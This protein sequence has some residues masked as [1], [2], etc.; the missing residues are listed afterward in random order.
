MNR[1][2]HPNDVVMW[3]TARLHQDGMVSASGTI[4]DKRMAL[5]LLDQA[6][7][8]IKRQV[9]EDN[10]VMI[11]NRDVSVMPSIPTK[12]MAHIPTSERGDG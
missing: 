1:V 5:H 8:A 6:R 3:I 4:A 7:D 11:P 2:D 10:A 12:D 9:P